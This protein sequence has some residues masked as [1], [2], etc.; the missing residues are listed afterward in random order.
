MVYA[1]SPHIHLQQSVANQ[2]KVKDNR[3]KEYSK[4]TEHSEKVLDGCFIEHMHY[5]CTRHISRWFIL[6]SGFKFP[7]H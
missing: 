6:N 1:D 4:S 2:S 7:E 3:S 5:R